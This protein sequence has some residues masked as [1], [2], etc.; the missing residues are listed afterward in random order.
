MFEIREKSKKLLILTALGIAMGSVF[1]ACKTQTVMQ[2]DY[3]ESKDNVITNKYVK[4]INDIANVKFETVYP[5]E[6][7]GNRQVGGVGPTDY[8]YRGIIYISDEENERLLNDYTWTEST[9]LPELGNNLRPNI[10][11]QDVWYESKPFEQEC[12]RL[13]S[14]PNIKFN[15]KGIIIFDFRST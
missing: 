9:D 6:Y 10:N 12:F 8:E 13:I 2:A 1:A 7:M 11:S 4:D 3:N 14:V 5:T 15:G